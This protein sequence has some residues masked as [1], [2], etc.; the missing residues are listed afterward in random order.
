MSFSRGSVTNKFDNVKSKEQTS[1]RFIIEPNISYFIK[2]HLAL[3][4]GFGYGIGRWKEPKKDQQTITGRF[5]MYSITPF[6]TKFIPFKS[7][8]FGFSLTGRFTSSFEKNVVETDSDI[9][10]V[11]ETVE[12]TNIIGGMIQPGLYFFPVPRFM[13]T[14]SPG[15]LLSINRSVTNQKDEFKTF[16]YKKTT[17][18]ILSLNT[19][20]LNIGCNYFF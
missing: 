10:G 3:G 14:G 12:S 5:S 9:Y 16:E 7:E 11:S 1:Y 6:V 15:D 18:K 4:L 17:I 8:K 13:I 19:L 2:P 20:N